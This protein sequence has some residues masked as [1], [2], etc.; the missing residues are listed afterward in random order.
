MSD[1]QQGDIH[2]TFRKGPCGK[3]SPWNTWLQVGA[4][5]SGLSSRMRIANHQIKHTYA[6]FTSVFLECNSDI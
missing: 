1:R 4:L 5:F 2:Y 3:V 6:T